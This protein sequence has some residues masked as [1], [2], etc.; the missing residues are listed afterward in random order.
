MIMRF[1]SDEKKIEKKLLKFED[2][3]KITVEIDFSKYRG[4]IFI[5]LKFNE[6]K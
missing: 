6:I 2:D 1:K 3:R 5:V 4:T